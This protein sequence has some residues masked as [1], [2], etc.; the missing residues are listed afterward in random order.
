M[1]EIFTMSDCEVS[2]NRSRR[3]FLRIRRTHETANDLPRVLR[4]LDDGDERW[5]L[6][7]ERDELLVVLLA[8]VLGVVTLG[9]G[10]V[11]GAQF[12]RDEVQLLGLDPAEYRTDETALH[13]VGLHDE[14]RSIHDEAIYSSLGQVTRAHPQHLTTDLSDEVQAARHHNEVFVSRAL[15]RVCQRRERTRVFV[16][17]AAVSTHGVGD[18]VH[19]D[20][21]R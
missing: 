10:E 7:D 6:G 2:S 8:H 12:G 14:E 21:S 20:R 18:L 11:D 5:T 17:D 3:G 15:A 13:A 1:Y 9:R 4:S 19:G 16:R